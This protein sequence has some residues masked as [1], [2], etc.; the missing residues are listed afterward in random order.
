MQD[1]DQEVRGFILFCLERCS[2][3]DWLTLYDEMCRVAAQG[4]YHHLGYKELRERGI[5]F[6]L[7][8]IDETYRIVEAVISEASNDAS[9]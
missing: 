6:G 3:K 4:L 9:P 2:S 5:S 1:I 8:K 7:N